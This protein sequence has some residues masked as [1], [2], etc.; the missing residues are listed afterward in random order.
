[1]RA[2]EMNRYGGPEVLELVELPEPEP[3][4]G[5]VLIDIDAA[6]VNYADTHQTENGYLTPTPLPFVPG[7]EAVGRT[8][9]GRRV[10]ALVGHGGYAEVALA[11]AAAVIDLPEKIDDGAA[12]AIALQ[13]LTAYH[14][15]RT[16][17]RL[18]PDE[19]V[20]VHA[21][22]GGVGTLAVQLA[23]I[24]GGGRVI[25]T[26][27]TVMKRQL[28]LDL[29]ADAAIDSSA[30]DLA[31]EIREANGGRRVD[32]VLEMIGGSAFTASVEALAPF[33]RL[34]TYGAAGRE[35]AQPVAPAA[36]M[37]RS[38]GIVGFLA[39]DCFTRPGMYSDPIEEMLGF[40]LDGQLRPVIGATYPLSQARAAHE[41]LLARKTTGKLVLDPSA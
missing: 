27:S 21:A 36:L 10:L 13:G 1:M 32:V 34:V 35:P 33:G 39:T 20:L 9:N 11:P 8:R 37:Q 2:I 24:F 41:D 30:D 6:G 5:G 18:Q 19:A 3:A 38:R 16:S 14:V 25:A 29:G 26:A 31:S 28:A 40:V 17:A 15:L 4:N 22:A 7:I 23:K 12:L